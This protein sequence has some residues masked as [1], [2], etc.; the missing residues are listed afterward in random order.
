MEINLGG[1]SKATCNPDEFA[2]LVKLGVFTVSNPGIAS[3]DLAP[4]TGGMAPAEPQ[5]LAAEAI[6]SSAE[7][8]NQIDVNTF[9]E[10]ISSSMG[11]IA[12]TV[13]RCGGTIK[14]S[15]LVEKTGIRGAA[16]RRPN[17]ALNKRIRR[18]FRKPDS[19]FLYGS[20][21]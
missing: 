20:G 6:A 17:G 5:S 3:Q 16:L 11:K 4:T 21:A 9:F 18:A 13:L 14:Q 15:E 1:L 7:S 12:I 2:Q 19:R 10:S 8:S